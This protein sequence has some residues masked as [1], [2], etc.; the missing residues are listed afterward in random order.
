MIGILEY[1]IIYINTANE[2]L[3]KPVKNIN[4]LQSCNVENLD[5]VGLFVKLFSNSIYSRLYVAIAS[6]KSSRI[7]FCA[8]ILYVFVSIFDD[9]YVLLPLNNNEFK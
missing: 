1:D 6:F 7:A 5:G 3:A 8:L 9:K 2:K 4:K